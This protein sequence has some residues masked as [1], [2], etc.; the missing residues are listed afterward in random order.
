MDALLVPSFQYRQ[1]LPEMQAPRCLECAS[2]DQDHSRYTSNTIKSRNIFSKIYLSS[3]FMLHYS[4]LFMQL[5]NFYFSFAFFFFVC[6]FF[7]F[8]FRVAVFFLLQILCHFQARCQHHCYFEL[9][10]VF[11]LLVVFFA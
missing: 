3:V 5:N 6:F 7:N 9:L 8:N 11:F 1:A 2:Q 4:F 10:C